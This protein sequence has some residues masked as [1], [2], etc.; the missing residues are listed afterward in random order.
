MERQGD[1]V[2]LHTG[3]LMPMIG[4]GTFQLAS[5]ESIVNAI[6]NLGYRH[7]DTAWLYMNEGLI[8]EALDEVF[9]SSQVKREDLF[10]VTKIWPT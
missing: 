8:G 7:I 9:K 5:K 4:L 10:V 3:A 6:V 1:K 2:K